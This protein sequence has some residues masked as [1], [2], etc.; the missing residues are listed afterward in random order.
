M[1]IL[2]A[3]PYPWPFDDA[4]SGDRL[5][6]VI[7]GAQNRFVEASVGSATVS[8]AL[9]ALALAVHDAGGLTVALRHGRRD[10]ARPPV[11]EVGTP[12]WEL[13]GVPAPLDLVVDCRGFDGCYGSTL[14]HELRAAGRNQI[15]LAGYASEI[16][17]DSTVRRLNDSGSECL[18][19]TDACA[20]LDVHTG[21][22]AHASLTMSGGI[23]GALA[24]TAE[25]LAALAGL[26]SP[27]PSAAA[28]PM[29]ATPETA[30]SAR[31]T[32]LPDLT[33]SLEALEA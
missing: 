27:L 20:P 11:P 5:A 7:A 19:V 22:R 33:P 2:S 13:A 25:V 31:P 28:P 21:A 29:I 26:G 16:T 24:T 23:F 10:T 3:N 18:V 12:Q 14:Q 1:A 6:L 17:V 4:L 30:A 32:A 15:L 9:A 8:A